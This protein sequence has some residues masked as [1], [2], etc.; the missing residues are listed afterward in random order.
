MEG[1]NMKKIIMD[2]FRESIDV[3]EKSLKELV[4][5]IEETS[6]KIIDCYRKGG[7]LIVF[8]NGGS[9]ADA[10]HIVAELVNKL[11]F[12]RPMLNA[13]ALTVNTSV[14]TAIGNDSSYDNVFSRQIESLAKPGDVI[15]GISTS[16]NSVNVVKAMEKAKTIGALTIGM[17]GQDGGKLKSF[18]D[19][20]LNVPSKK[21]QRIQEVHITIGHI[22]C[23]L[24]EEKIFGHMKG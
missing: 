17:T 19:I 4:D 15:M 13:L 21:T 14:L 7:K 22:I 9:A 20:L 18:S 24:V 3:K 12:D 2:E 11:N 8:G 1:V 5:K 6:K 23:G 16:G 10:Q